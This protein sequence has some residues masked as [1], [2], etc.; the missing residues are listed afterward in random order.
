MSDIDYKYNLR[1]IDGKIYYDYTD[2]EVINREK[3][4]DILDNRGLTSKANYLGKIKIFQ[5]NKLHIDILQE[6]DFFLNFIERNNRSYDFNKRFLYMLSIITSNKPYSYYINYQELFARTNSEETQT[7]ISMNIVKKRIDDLENIYENNKNLINLRNL[8][9]IR[10]YQDIECLRLDFNGYIDSP[11]YSDSNYFNTTTKTFHLNSYKTSHIYGPDEYDI[12]DHLNNLIIEYKMLFRKRYNKKHFKY[13]QLLVSNKKPLTQ[14]DYSKLLSDILGISKPISKLRRGKVYSTLSKHNFTYSDDI[15]NELDELCKSMKHTRIV[16]DI[17]YKN[18]DEFI[19]YFKNYVNG[20]SVENNTNS[21]LIFYRKQI[22]KIL[23]ELTNDI[24][25]DNITQNKI[26]DRSR[27]NLVFAYENYD[28]NIYINI[29][30][31]DD[32]IQIEY[33]DEFIKIEKPPAD[34]YKTI[35]KHINRLIE[36][37]NKDD[38]EEKKLQDVI[39]QQISTSLKNPL[40]R[41]IN[42]KDLEIQRL[43]EE[44]NKLK[45]NTSIRNTNMIVCEC[46]KRLKRINKKHLMSKYHLSHQ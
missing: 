44:N 11:E 27:Y 3:L 23:Y 6:K 35:V 15:E 20:V 43:I 36:K 5:N 18:D 9:L 31:N 12:P 24:I 46:G 16:R 29:W 17:H 10:C 34:M 21:K 28:Y 41:I 30:V 2:G 22:P 45:S 7:F 33:K 42:D 8:I 26:I 13:I 1:V 37:T 40:R 39:N 25:R 19:R 38:T 4:N 32:Y 14:K